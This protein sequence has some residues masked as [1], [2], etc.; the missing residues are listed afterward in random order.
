M[1]NFPGLYQETADLPLELSELRWSIE[2]TFKFF[3]RL[4]NDK[5]IAWLIELRPNG[6]A[7]VHDSNSNLVV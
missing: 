1:R 2:E 7:I 4:A 3:K 5:D 6:Y